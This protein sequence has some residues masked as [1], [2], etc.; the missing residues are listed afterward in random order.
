M[1]KTV[2]NGLGVDVLVDVQD[3]NADENGHE[4]VRNSL[5]ENVESM[6]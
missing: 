4:M 1:T 3:P 5:V 2:G 6:Q